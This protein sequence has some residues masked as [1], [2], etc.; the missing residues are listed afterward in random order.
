MLNS[1]RSTSLGQTLPAENNRLSSGSNSH[2]TMGQL[3]GALIEVIIVF[4]GL[5]FFQ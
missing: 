2:S 4:S 3:L 1:I 5:S